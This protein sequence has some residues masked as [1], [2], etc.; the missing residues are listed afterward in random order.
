MQANRASDETKDRLA[1][2]LQ[3]PATTSKSAK[4][5]LAWLSNQE[6][7]SAVSIDPEKKAQLPG[8][9]KQKIESEP[10]LKP[11]A[12]PGGGGS[13]LLALFGCAS[14]RK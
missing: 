4:D 3:S 9:P 1:K 13:S 7:L 12:S 2:W 5:D 6:D 11:Q 8:E 14:K 10:S